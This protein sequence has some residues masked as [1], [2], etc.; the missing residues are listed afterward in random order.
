MA[1][2]LP[3]T[4][5]GEATSLAETTTA[6]M[7]RLVLFVRAIDDRIKT[8]DATPE[9]K[10]ASHNFRLAAEAFYEVL[11]IYKTTFYTP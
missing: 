9:I 7:K 10:S 8:S 2:R 5:V 1:T 3:L 6:I 11:V 4:S